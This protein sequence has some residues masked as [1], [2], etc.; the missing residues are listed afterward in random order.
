MEAA[1]DLDVFMEKLRELKSSL[2]QHQAQCVTDNYSTDD[3]DPNQPHSFS[4]FLDEISKI[5]ALIENKHPLESQIYKFIESITSL[6]P[7]F[8]GGGRSFVAIPINATMFEI[9]H[10]VIKIREVLNVFKKNFRFGQMTRDYQK[11]VNQASGCIE[12]PE[13]LTCLPENGG[14]PSIDIAIKYICNSIVLFIIVDSY[15]QPAIDLFKK[16]YNT[17]FSYCFNMESK[18]STSQQ[19]SS[20]ESQKRKC[21]LDA[22][23]TITNKKNGLSTYLISSSQPSSSHGEPGVMTFTSA[24]FSYAEY[25]SFLHRNAIIT[26]LIHML[27]KIKN[28]TRNERIIPKD[29]KKTILS[30][31]LQIPSLTEEMASM[32]RDDAVFVGTSP[33]FV[34]LID[35]A[36][37]HNAV[38]STIRFVDRERFGLSVFLSRKEFIRSDV[39][40]GNAIIFYGDN[41][42][43]FII[44]DVKTNVDFTFFAD[45]DPVK[46]TTKIKEKNIAL[47]D[48][49]ITS[50]DTF[51]ADHLYI[52][53]ALNE[54][55]FPEDLMWPSIYK[56][57]WMS[58]QGVPKGRNL[59]GLTF[60]GEDDTM[61]LET[62]FKEVVPFQPYCDDIGVKIYYR[63][64]KEQYLIEM[65]VH[66]FI[67]K[68]NA[69]FDLA[70]Y[71]KSKITL[72]PVVLTLQCVRSID[73]MS[74][75]ELVMMQIRQ[76]T[77]ERRPN[78]IIV[79]HDISN[80]QL[81]D[82]L[83]SHR[84]L[85][86]SRFSSHF[87]DKDYYPTPDE[88]T[89]HDMKKY[90]MVEYTC[91]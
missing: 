48:L 27:S 15:W 86:I 18:A 63:R 26:T 1:H 57:R 47:Q 56:S 36:H 59:Y 82:F 8:P 64:I 75:E 50:V 46:F 14:A 40:T 61:K 80:K 66:E 79:P 31:K 30:S 3:D 33:I 85:G 13:I 16:T 39:F 34:R 2:S 84:D 25:M 74:V 19:N 51:S 58:Y 24:N 67:K 78:R 72:M 71:D 91:Q 45:T 35:P 7:G 77:I 20:V 54:V 17:A 22:R 12:N 4:I 6:M 70:V 81:D 88:E 83:R 5:E 73:K 90:Y 43:V 11:H 52:S 28:T 76:N 60:L 55:I 49:C 32:L 44:N 69:E 87:V 9:G 42:G 41:D 89:S 38:H 68:S 53:R 62:V 65:A 37:I 10:I 21:Y 23:E 29:Y